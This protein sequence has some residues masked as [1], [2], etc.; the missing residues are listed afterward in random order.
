VKEVLVLGDG[1]CPADN[2]NLNEPPLKLSTLETNANIRFQIDVFRTRFLRELPERLDDLLRIAA[3]VYAADTRVSRGTEKDVF[4]D[5]WTRRFQM[6]LP[7]WDIDFW[8]MPA[9]QD[10]LIETLQFFTGDEYDFE[11][12]RRSYGT[13]LQGILQFKEFPGYIPDV[14]VILLFS[15]GADSLAAAIEAWADGLH[16]ILVSHRSAPIIDRRQKN[17]VELLQETF[18]GWTFPHISMWVNRAGGSRP[19]EFTQRSRSFLFAALGVVTAAL[20]DIDEIRLC[21]NGIVSIN[22]PQSGQNIG[23]LLSRSTHPR[24]LTYAQ[25]FMQ[26]VTERDG[27]AIRNTLLFKTKKEVLDTIAL[28]GHPELLQETVSCSHVEGKTKQKPHCGVCS[29]CVDRRFASEA[30]SLKEHDLVSRYEKDIFLDSLDEGSKRTHAENYV[31]FAMKLEGL[32][33]PDEFF[34]TFPELYDCLPTTGDIETFA[35]NLWE[36][37]QRHYETVNGTLEKLIQQYAP[38]LLRASLPVTCLLRIVTSGQHIID[39]RIRFIERLRSLLCASLPPAFQTHSATNERQVQD[40]GES[41][42]QAAQ[43]RLHRETPQLPFATVSTKPDFSD[44]PVNEPPLFIEFKYSKNR[45]DLRK[46]NTEMTSRV[47]VYKDQGAWILFIVYD[48]NRTITDDEKFTKAFEKHER[49]WVG[50]SR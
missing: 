46:I 28:S 44:I 21:D 1:A 2:F 32:Q 42:F 25:K 24:F 19:K 43:E 14:D 29:Q 31:R 41:V 36:L 50:I 35:H 27:L 17:L 7:V 10:S 15:G 30:A 4:G 5:N 45:G 48:P 49:V 38:E 39:P 12:V 47:T 20:L 11:F 22:L 18:P 26:A 13:P 37:F 6:V 16:P 8:N 33:N 3:F 40:T 9:I 23:T 34:T